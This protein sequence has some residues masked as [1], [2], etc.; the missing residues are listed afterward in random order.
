MSVV[1][2]SS[3]A[4]APTKIDSKLTNHSV[5]VNHCPYCLAAPSADLVSALQS[6]ADATKA[7]RQLHASL[8]STSIVADALTLAADTLPVATIELTKSSRALQ[9]QL[10]ALES[11]IRRGVALLQASQAAHPRCAVCTRVAG[12]GHEV[13]ALKREPNGI[14]SVC[15]ECYR[16]LMVRGWSAARLVRHWLED[17]QRERRE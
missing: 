4:G 14:A 11:D 16:D 1:N 13:L 7:I 12:V 6:S 9:L 5:I 8:S 3:L 10:R 2:E 15:D 17:E